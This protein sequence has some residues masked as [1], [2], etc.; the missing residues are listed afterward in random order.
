M[1]DS[2]TNHTHQRGVVAAGFAAAAAGALIAMAGGIAPAHADDFGAV[3]ADI[4]GVEALGQADLGDAAAAFE[5]GGTVQGLADLMAGLDDSSVAPGE[6]LLLGGSDAITGTAL[7]DSSW[8]DFDNTL[9]TPTS[10]SDA[11]A[12]ATTLTSYGSDFL[13]AGSEA[14]AGG[15]VSTGLSDL[16]IAV[17][18]FGIF[19]PQELVLGLASGF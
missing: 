19:D 6:W 2:R 5:G 8:F 14:F 12:D 18:F 11:V 15:D 3:V 9:I 13:T 16:L 4:Q 10:W 1:T 7:P 17:D